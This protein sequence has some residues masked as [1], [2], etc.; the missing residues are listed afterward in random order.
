MDILEVVINHIIESGL[1]AKK[2]TDIFKQYTP[3]ELDRAVTVFEV[4]GSRY[5]HY[6]GMAVRRVHILV[7]D[8]SIRTATQR[9]WDI[10][11]IFDSEEQVITMGG[12]VYPY[13]IVGLPRRTSIDKEG[14]HHVRLD[15]N[16]TVNNRIQED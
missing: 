11:S 12:T 5:H 14:R 10:F 7:R 13:S 1:C 8:K 15:V 16:F 3:D 2:D 9:C 6:S 4:A